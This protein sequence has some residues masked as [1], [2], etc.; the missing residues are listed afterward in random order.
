MII[1]SVLPFTRAVSVFGPTSLFLFF[2]P[3]ITSLG[4]LG[5]VFSPDLGLPAMLNRQPS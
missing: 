5:T 1:P 2:I 3:A 4:T